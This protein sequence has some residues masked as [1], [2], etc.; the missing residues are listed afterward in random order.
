MRDRQR[1]HTRGERGRRRDGDAAL[2]GRL[3]TA[4]AGAGGRTPAM[5]TPHTGADAVHQEA[6]NILALT[7]T[8]SAIKGGMNMP[9]VG[10]TM[11]D[12]S[13]ITPQRAVCLLKILEF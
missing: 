2:R 7:Q 11:G 10:D 8:E 13:G 4:A 5:L 6:A 12:F 3:H 9:I 1:A